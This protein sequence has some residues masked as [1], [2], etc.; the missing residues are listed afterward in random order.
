MLTLICLVF[1]LYSCSWEGRSVP[2]TPKEGGVLLPQR[3]I[4]GKA[5]QVCQGVPQP[6]SPSEESCI[7]Q[8]WTRL[9]VS[10]TLR[11]WL[12]TVWP[13]Q[14][15]PR[16]RCGNGFQEAAAESVG[17]SPALQLE[18]FGTPPHGS[19]GHREKPHVSA[20]LTVSAK[21]PD[22]HQHQPPAT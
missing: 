18:I 2:P 8:E 17:Q 15:W 12:G 11:H 10:A 7:L 3:A 22:S 13:W 5:R 16:Y 9:S 4:S 20:P 6:G 1:P 19:P 21:V 14:G